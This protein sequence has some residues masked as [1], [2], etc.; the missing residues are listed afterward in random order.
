MSKRKG[1]GSTVALVI[2]VTL[3]LLMLFGVLNFKAEDMNDF[4]NLLR[5]LMKGFS[6]K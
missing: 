1:G 5:D 4:F 2:L 6:G 3:G